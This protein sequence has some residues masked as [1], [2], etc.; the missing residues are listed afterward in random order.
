MKKSI[1]LFVFSVLIQSI[2][3]QN[4][5]PALDYTVYDQ[6]KSL[7]PAM[8]SGNGEFVS[9]E[10][11][12]SVGDGYLHFLRLNSGQKI[13]FPRGDGAVFSPNNDFMAFK[14][15]IF[16]DTLRQA[17]L[18]KVKKEKMPKDSLAIYLPKLNKTVMWANLKSFKVPAEGQSVIAFML[19]EEK[20]EKEEEKEE[21]VEELE[22]AEKAEKG[23][24]LEKVEKKKSKKKKSKKK[25]YKGSRLDILYPVRDDTSSF[26][27]VT[28]YQFGRKGNML[29]V[30]SIEE[31]SVN[32]SRIHVMDTESREVTMIWDKQ[33]VTKKVSGD[34]LFTKL[35]F[36]H[37]EDTTKV[38]VYSLY[39]W[40][41]KMK[42]ASLLADSLTE[43]MPEGFVVSENGSLRFSEDGKMLFVGTSEKPVIEEEQEDSL[44]SDEKV[45]IDIWHW[46]DPVLQSMQL[47]RV[48]REE[49]KTFQ[50]LINLKKQKFIQLGEEG[51]LE[52]FRTVNLGNSLHAL[53]LDENPYELSN[54]VNFRSVKDV[55][56]TNL[57]TGEDEL[58]FESVE[59][60]PAIS[61]FGKYLY[62]WEPEDSN[63]YVYHIKN[64]EILNLTEG[65]D[66]SFAIDNNDYPDDTRSYGS[67]GWT[68]DD[69]S[70]YIYD[71][72]DIWRFDPLG[73]QPAMNVSGQTGRKNNI[74]LRYSRL[75]RDEKFLNENSL[76]FFQAFNYETK[77]SGYYRMTLSAGQ[78]EKVIMGD[79]RYGRLNKSKDAG[80]L[81]WTRSTVHDY[82]DLYTSDMDF[83]GSKKISETNPQQ[84]DYNWLTCE[85][86][87]WFDYDGVRHQGLLYKPEDFDPNKKY[88][89]MVYFYRLHSDGLHRYITPK[90]SSSTINAAFYASN[91]YLVF[92]PD[93][94][95]KIGQPG[96]SAFNSIVSGVMS[97]GKEFSCI[98]ME[99][100]GLQGQ[101]W[102]GYQAAYIITQTDLF[103]A[104][105][106]GAPVSN[107]TSAYG[108]I[109]IASGMCR[110]VQYEKGQS[111]IGGTL[112]EKPV[113]Y[114]E[115]SPLFYAPQCNTPCLIRHND[116]D[117][118]VPFA[119]GVEFFVALRRLGK[120]AWLLNYNNGPHN[121][122]KKLSNRKDLSVR[123]KQFFDHYLKGESAPEWL[124]DGVKAVDKKQSETF[125][126]QYTK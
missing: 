89:M 4:S 17:K 106:P 114:Y 47:K 71:K 95:F 62:W 84:E 14:I 33:G 55:Y 61:P 36:I 37:S 48:S 81:I 49:K 69:D 35:A 7:S 93:V 108:G 34:E 66:V 80:T 110:Q 63:Y 121:L 126:L 57:L 38:K 76:Y 64:R 11:N 105:S 45:H 122:T 44:L 24:E 12:P 102:G 100:I 82:P 19:E 123:M 42:M 99:H 98:D 26:E 125:Y 107:M 1:L 2:T 59:F 68:E 90:A 39:Y 116:N 91:G 60:S 79:Y 15:K 118:A 13:I 74:R 8:I 120:P 40:D 3:A 30:T 101:S 96:R 104:A 103:A 115:N 21:K 83:K 25:E 16:A 92:M 31:D 23:E 75:D 77:E 73:K 54:E 113:E 50:A 5:K 97:L 9:F 27:N 94:Y 22:K 78:L 32:T 43:G 58:I 29:V 109:R 70:W 46:Q 18:D 6:W 41:S 119:Q 67:M 112:W 86:V 124:S 65:L 88:P 20:E 51:F 111:R 28:D 53:A 87:E 72:Y 85:L 117:G 10:I 56:L 52:S